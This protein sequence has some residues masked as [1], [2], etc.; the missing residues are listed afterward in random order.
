MATAQES[1]DHVLAMTKF[2]ESDAVVFANVDGTS[3]NGG[4]EWQALLSRQLTE[5]V[6]FL[7]SVE[8]IPSTVIQTVELPPGSVLT[9]LTKRIRTFTEQSLAQP[10]EELS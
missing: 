10:R 3:R 5:P 2:Q 9:G 7:R 6:Q 8:A 1:L 4:D